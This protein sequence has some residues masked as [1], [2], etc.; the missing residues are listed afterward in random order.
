MRIAAP[1]TAFLVIASIGY[2]SLP[3]VNEVG[4]DFPATLLW[5]FRLSSLATQATLWLVLGLA[6]AFLTERATQ[7]AE[8]GKK[9]ATR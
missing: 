4:E 2:V 1:V 8:V 5:E 7:N 3:G 9:F 6:F